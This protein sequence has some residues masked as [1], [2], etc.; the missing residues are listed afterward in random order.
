MENK[1]NE[2]VHSQQYSALQTLQTH[3]LEGFFPHQKRKDTFLQEII[4]N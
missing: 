2:C 4:I 3:H 1:L